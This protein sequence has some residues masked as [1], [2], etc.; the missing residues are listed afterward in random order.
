MDI[1]QF[2]L[3][4]DTG[5]HDAGDELLRQLAILIKSQL[6]G[7]DLLGRVG[8]DEFGVILTDCS[9]ERAESISSNL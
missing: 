2:K 3:V 7:F 8:G 4:N 1:D 9:V 5:G 6:K